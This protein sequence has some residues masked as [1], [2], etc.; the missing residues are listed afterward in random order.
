[1]S[2]F[3]NGKLGLILS[4]GLMASANAFAYGGYTAI[5]FEPNANQW[6][7]FHG[8]YSRADAETNAMNLCGATCQGVDAYTLEAGQSYLHETWAYNGWVAYAHG[9]NNSHWGTSGI[10]DSQ[11]DAEQSAL[12]NCG[13]DANQCYVVRSLSSF[14]YSDDISGTNTA[15]Q[16]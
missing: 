11:Y 5:V 1:M 13:G 3:L 10:H 8:S 12:A 14:V 15:G 4:L 16:F 6:G 7:S 9:F 2:K